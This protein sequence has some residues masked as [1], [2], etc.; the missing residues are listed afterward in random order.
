MSVYLDH[1]ATTPV[2]PPVLALMGAVLAETGNPSSLHSQGRAARARVENARDQVAALA[3][4]RSQNVVF[5]SGAAEANTMIMKGHSG[6]AATSAI[7]HPTVRE[8]NLEAIRIPVSADGVLDLIALERILT[9]EKPELVAVMAVNNE[10]GVIQPVEEIGR[11]C[12]QHGA[13]FHCDAV[14][15]AGKIDID[16]E[17]WN[18]DFMT[19]SAHKMGG[20]QGMGALLYRSGVAVPKLIFGGGQEKR[21]R[22]GTENVAGIAGLGLAAE[23]ALKDKNDYQKL[24]N[25]R[26]KMERH[27]NSVVVHGKDAKRIANTSCFSL[28]GRKADTLL[29]ALDL[30]GIAISSGSAC[31]S[32]SVR[33]SHV[34]KA[35]GVDDDLCAGALRISLG[36]D[37]AE[38]DVDALVSALQ[39]ILH[40]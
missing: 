25:W 18:C 39:N 12:K 30:K 17:K 11:L 14:Q 32:G 33:A 16:F 28:R 10:T 20:P 26:D 34:L 23:L 36:W 31:S 13:L 40:A 4:Y 22:A 27:L 29:M 35:M 5:T 37:S 7:E 21:Q 6:K 3:G 24:G 2:K 38:K 19:L 15:A 8:A 9:E 1:N